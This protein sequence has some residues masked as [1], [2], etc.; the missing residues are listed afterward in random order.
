MSSPAATYDL[1]LLL[2]PQAEETRRAKLVSDASAAITK[3][4]ELLRHD[5]WGERQLA[6]HVGRK[7]SAEYHLMQFHAASPELLG[8]LDRSLRIADE[9][10]RFRLIKLRPGVPEAPDMRPGAAPPRRAANGAERTPPAEAE[11]DSSAPEAPSEPAA[12]AD[13]SAPDAPS[14]PAAAVPSREAEGQADS[15]ESD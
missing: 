2:D 13:S 1:L 10:L 11:A 4:G 14:E 9:V 12:A 15:G 6:Y 7:E 3:Q 8:S 5:S